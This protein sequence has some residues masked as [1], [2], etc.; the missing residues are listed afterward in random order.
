[1]CAGGF[2]PEGVTQ[3]MAVYEQ[4][5]QAYAKI[6]L[7]LRIEGKRP[8]GYHVLST[9][10]QSISLYDDVKVIC[11]DHASRDGYSPGITLETDAPYLPNN[12]KNTAH[13]AAR[14]FMDALGRKNIA[15]QMHITKNIPSQA[16]LGGG[17]TDAAAVLTA[18]SNI[19]PGAIDR[20]SL[21]AMASEIGADVPFCMDGG[22]Q[23]CEGIGDILRPVVPMSG[24]PILLVKPS[25][26]ISTP[27]A[28]A[29]YD[30][31][32][33]I[34]SNP[35]EEAVAIERMISAK[36]STDPI[37]RISDAASHL[38]NDLESVA[39]NEYPVLADIRSFLLSQGAKLARMSG[40]GSAVFGIFA[41]AEQRDAARVSAENYAGPGV[42]L[43]SGETK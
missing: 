1:M 22:T 17:S 19:F 25:C 37:R 12:A 8:D 27:R 31:R 13:R 3:Q 33:V 26:G 43:Y 18:L 16:G 15:V 24:M 39:E 38:Y 6:N 7:F 35:D 4:N 20:S 5:I 32:P 29:Q 42:Y 23:L 40:S 36:D 14:A 11:S 21:F 9:L 2:F 28:Y 10:M 30:D 34:H 41:N